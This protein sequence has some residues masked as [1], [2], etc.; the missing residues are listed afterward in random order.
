MLVPVLKPLYI[1]NKK[2]NDKHK[3]EDVIKL[4]LPN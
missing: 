1:E 2:T 3:L 4:I